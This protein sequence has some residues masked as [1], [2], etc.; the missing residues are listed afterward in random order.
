M[1]SR[2]F[3]LARFDLG[4][5][6]LTFLDM[7]KKTVVEF[8]RYPIAFISVFLQIFLIVLMFLFAAFTFTP[9]GTELAEGQRMAGVLVYGLVIQMFLSFTLW[10]IGFSVR[11]EQVRGTLE[12]LYLSPANKFQSLVSRVFAVL[13]WTSA[14]TILAIATVAAITRGLPAHN[15]P[16]ALLVLLLTISGLLGLGF[17]FA[18]I[19]I[20]LKETAQLLVSFLQFF[21]LIFCAMFFP[22]NALPVPLVAHVSRWIPL[23]YCVD[24]FRSLLLGA[25]PE[26]APLGVELLIVLG[27][28]V[29]SPIAGFFAYRAA[30]R[31]SR[32][33]GVL[34]EY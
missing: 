5:A 25:T 13:L 16:L 33:R 15:I 2:G 26:L 30:E 21:F 22:F 7:S 34:G 6:V 23:S 17:I 9:P 24:A 29:A 4:Q 31:D 3:G 18:G 32:R 14:V 27:F 1:A 8:S 10:Q 20:L 12:A 11:E 19:T 28:A